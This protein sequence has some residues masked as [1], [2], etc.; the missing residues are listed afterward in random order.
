MDFFLGEMFGAFL[1]LLLISPVIIL[2][3]G[4]LVKFDIDNDGKNDY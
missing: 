1:C 3:A 2:I 4:M